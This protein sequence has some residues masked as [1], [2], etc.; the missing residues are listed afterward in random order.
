MFRPNFFSSIYQIGSS[1]QIGIQQIPG[2]F[3]WS[4]RLSEKEA[5]GQSLWL[6]A[7]GWFRS[8]SFVW[9]VWGLVFQM[10]EVCYIEKHPWWL[11]WC[12]LMLLPSL[13]SR[14]S[15]E[16]PNQS[17]SRNHRSRKRSRNK[18]KTKT[19]R[20]FMEFHMFTWFHKHNF[21]TKQLGTSSFG[22]SNVVDPVDRIG[23]AKDGVEG[24]PYQFLNDFYQ[25]GFNAHFMRGVL[26]VMK[27]ALFVHCN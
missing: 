19:D 22:K 23:L 9:R 17:H 18:E 25:D 6:G 1:R 20:D 7:D 13:P 2:S 26:Q 12:L 5:T 24:Y 4:R 15:L 8:T 21:V 14:E 27:V 11:W 16:R 3:C 10:L